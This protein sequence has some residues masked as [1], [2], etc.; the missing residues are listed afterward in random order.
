MKYKY[1]WK[2]LRFMR[3]FA[4]IITVICG[5]SILI[6]LLTEALPSLSSYLE[7]Y[8]G[9]ALIT[10]L[11]SFPCA[12]AG[13]YGYLDALHYLKRLSLWGIA[14]PY[15]KDDALIP[16]ADNPELLQEG[17][18][19]RSSVILAIAAFIIS[20]GILIAGIVHTLHY[21]AL[22][23]G[24]DAAAAAMMCHGPLCIAWLIGGV[25]YF[26][27][28]LNEKYRDEADPVPSKKIRSNIF[29]GSVT[30]LLC[31]GISLALLSIP[32]SMS[33]Y[34]Y[35][36]KLQTCYGDREWRDHI[37]EPLP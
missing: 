32:K 28:R 16:P 1:G 19:C 14:I 6:T 25:V 22:G 18:V 26:H 11:V 35:K 23:V 37:G 27:Q 31:L 8:S 24:S 30:I 7:L 20:G 3:V 36:S 10:L 2:D 9:G 4:I 34:I 12:L 33:D 21:T 15:S 17:A 13:W 5:L 29:K